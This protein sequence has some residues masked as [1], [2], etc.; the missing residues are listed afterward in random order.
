[1]E[2]HRLSKLTHCV[3]WR[4]QLQLSLALPSSTNSP[5]LLTLI[6]IWELTDPCNPPSISL[7]L[8]PTPFQFPTTHHPHCS[9]WCL[10]SVGVKG[11]PFTETVGPVLKATSHCGCGRERGSHCRYMYLEPGGQLINTISD[12]PPHISRYSECDSCM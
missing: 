4:M 9:P 12:L 3:E 1:M 8:F 11:Q 2:L 7:P 10:W 5:T 6:F